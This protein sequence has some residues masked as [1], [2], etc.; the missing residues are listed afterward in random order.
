MVQDVG[1]L[2]SLCVMSREVIITFYQRTLLGT[3]ANQKR[4]Y[5][6]SYNNVNYSWFQG[7]NVQIWNSA[8]LFRL[9]IKKYFDPGFFVKINI[10]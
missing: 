2:Y 5:L 4:H 9:I 7:Q 6:K 10:I 1:I 3:S 8:D